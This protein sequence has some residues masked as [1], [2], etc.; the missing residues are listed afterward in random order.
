[1]TE[2]RGHPVPSQ[3]TPDGWYDHVSLIVSIKNKQT[4]NNLSGGTD[5]AGKCSCF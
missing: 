4:K 3:Q 1:M 5:N 2:I